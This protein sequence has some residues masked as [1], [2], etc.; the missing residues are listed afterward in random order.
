MTNDERWRKIPIDLNDYDIFSALY[1]WAS[2][3]P[4]QERHWS[5]SKFTSPTSVSCHLCWRISD[6]V[7]W[8]ERAAQTPEE[9]VQ[10]ALDA[11]KE[12]E[13]LGVEEAVLPGS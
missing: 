11:F 3:K 1:D 4:E 8:I 10:K 6:K 9:A 7:A 2:S 5:V 13:Y 12:E